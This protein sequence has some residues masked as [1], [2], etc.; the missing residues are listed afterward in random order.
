[1]G[2]LVTGA[3]G[4]VGQYVLEELSKKSTDEII[5]IHRSSSKNLKKI[6]NVKYIQ[7]DLKNIDKE[8][9]YD[10]ENPKNLIHLA[11][12][13][14]PNYDSNYHIDEELPIQLDFIK[15][16]ISCGSKNITISGTCF[17][18]G[19][20]SGCLHENDNLNPINR[21][22]EAKVR[23]LN[24]LIKLKKENNFN[25]TWARLFYMYGNGQNP[26]SLWPQIQNAVKNN[27]SEFNIASDQLRDYLHIENVAQYL[28]HLSLLNK[29]IGVVNVCSG[30]PIS[31]KE[32][33]EGWIKEYKWDIKLNLGRYP[34]SPNEPLSFWGNNNKLLKL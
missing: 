25:L 24:H 20:S 19:N 1:M 15:K 30:N 34:F 16:F 22:G 8:F 29:D 27:I 3:S 28:V 18:Y 31:I 6:R 23:L 2:I 33:V 17:E 10:V 13:N 26:K 21:Y 9:F 12:G 5:A 7:Q 32:L 11:W 14:L 4:F